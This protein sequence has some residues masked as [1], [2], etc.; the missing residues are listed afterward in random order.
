MGEGEGG[1]IVIVNILFGFE[2]FSSGVEIFLGWLR[3]VRGIEKK[4]FWGGLKYFWSGGWDIFRG[5]EKFSGSVEKF[6]GCLKIFLGIGR[7]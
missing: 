5:V 4:F 2:I 7:V 1:L 3:N 6:S